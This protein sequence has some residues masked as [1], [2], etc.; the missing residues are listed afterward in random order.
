M[1]IKTEVTERKFQPVSLTLTFETLEELQNM[2]VLFGYDNTVL[3]AVKEKEEKWPSQMQTKFN[4]ALLQKNMGN[5][6][7]ALKDLENQ[8]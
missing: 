5:I 1:Q 6:Y 3:S 7:E 8:L 4:K 2:R